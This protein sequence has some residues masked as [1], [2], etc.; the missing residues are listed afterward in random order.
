MIQIA[1]DGI[2][3]GAMCGGLATLVT[4]I[5]G[6]VWACRRDPSGGGGQHGAERRSLPP[7]D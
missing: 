5:A 6:L 4:A 3:F 1:F 7:T 2:G